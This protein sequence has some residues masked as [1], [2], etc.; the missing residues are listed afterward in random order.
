MAANNIKTILFDLGK[1]LISFDHSIASKRIAESSDCDEADIYNL[2]FDSDLTAEFE[3]GKVSPQEFFLKVK[4]RLGIRLEYN[5]FLA[6]WNEIFFVTDD[7]SRVHSLAISLKSKYSLAMLTNINCL[8]FNYIKEHYSILPDFSRV[9]TS[10]ELKLKKPDPA[11][12]KKVIDLLG[13]KPQE[14]FY[15]DDRPELIDVAK[16]LGMRAFI[17]KDFLQLKRDLLQAGIEP[18]P[19]SSLLVSQ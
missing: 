13:N 18:Q 10:F 1:V 6:V 2:F 5:E 4:E 8:H 7:N 3:E 19:E 17:F 16:S 14:I 9:F 12:Y 15:T 11:I